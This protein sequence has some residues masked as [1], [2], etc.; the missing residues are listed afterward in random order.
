M[1]IFCF[2]VFFLVSCP[3]P[4]NCIKITK[5]KKKKKKK[6]NKESEKKKK[7][8]KKKKTLPRTRI[9]FKPDFSKFGLSGFDADHLALFKKR[10]YDIAGTSAKDLKVFLNKERVPCRTFK[11]YVQLH[12]DPKENVPLAHFQPN[13][14]FLGFRCVFFF[15]Y[16]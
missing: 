11:D 15:L 9:T 14:R 1:L 8:K 3:E 13:D 10:V 12:F 4:L 6:K 7:K 5:K 16:Q 2:F